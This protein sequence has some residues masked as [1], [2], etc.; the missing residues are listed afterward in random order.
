MLGQWSLFLLL[1]P[2]PD[3]LGQLLVDVYCTYG[4]ACGRRKEPLGFLTVLS[5]ASGLR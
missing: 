5:G 2:P 3:P 1:P 4:I